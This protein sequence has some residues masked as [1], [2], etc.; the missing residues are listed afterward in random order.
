MPSTRKNPR[1]S[2]SKNDGR[3]A[4]YDKF[5]KGLT[6]AGIG[7]KS[8]MSRIDREEFFGVISQKGKKAF[9]VFTQEYN[10]ANMDEG[11]FDS[12][13]SFRLTVAK[14]E[15]AEPAL[16]IECVFQAHMHSKN[17]EPDLAERFSHSEMRFVM[18]P[19]ARQFVAGVTAQM[20][21][22]PVI[23]PLTTRAD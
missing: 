2:I 22:P 8:S 10:L 6:L 20:A 3:D 1:A 5:I 11:S 17:P 19:F 4:V 18:V 7:L 13:G 9:L 12:E 15:K 21:I 14:S 23:V 16:I